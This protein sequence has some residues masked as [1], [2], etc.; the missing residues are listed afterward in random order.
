M[1][2]CSYFIKDKCM[3][4]SFPTQESVNELEHEGV[5]YF[6]DLTYNEKENKKKFPYPHFY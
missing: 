2:Y 4:G 6:I 3:F 1:N 5:R